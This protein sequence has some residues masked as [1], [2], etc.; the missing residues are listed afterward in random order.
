MEEHISG[1][2]EIKEKVD[3][4]YALFKGDGVEKDVPK[5][6]ELFSEAAE[7]GS[8]NAMFW[9][10]A[11]CEN[12]EEYF[13]LEEGFQWFLKAA[14][15]DNPAAQFQVG[16]HYLHGKGVD[17]DYDQAFKWFSLSA[18]KGDSCSQNS[19]GTMYL[20]R[21]CPQAE[22]MD[23]DLR[24]RLGWEWL[25]KAAAQ[26]SVAGLYNLAG[27]YLKGVYVKED[28]DMAISLY[29]MA[30]K[31]DRHNERSQKILDELG[32]EHE[33]TDDDTERIKKLFS[34]ACEKAKGE[35]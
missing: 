15:M 14:E 27:M 17:L 21:Q 25:L 12:E 9:L 31:L 32:A 29:R 35:L 30:E 7:Q 33:V 23:N 4:A 19:L 1:V 34:N 3:L 10:G 11:I 26:N 20:R 13:S 24:L 22:D 5:A 18:D 16:C 28:K 8:T 6:Y 2:G